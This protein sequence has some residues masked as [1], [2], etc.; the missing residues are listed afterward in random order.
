MRDRMHNF[1]ASEG[2]GGYATVRTVLSGVNRIPLNG[3][4]VLV[5]HVRLRRLRVDDGRWG[6]KGKTI[7]E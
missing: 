7:R 1:F 3:S 5:S 4:E 2:W 6:Q